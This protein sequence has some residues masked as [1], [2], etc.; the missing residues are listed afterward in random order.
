M[1]LQ[2]HI[3]GSSP[4]DTR[5]PGFDCACGNSEF[6][7]V[8]IEDS[9]TGNILSCSRCGNA[10]GDDNEHR[11]WNLRTHEGRPVKTVKVYIRG[12]HDEFKAQFL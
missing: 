5:Q 10:Y 6:V 9:P 1:A 7:S 8:S 3:G 4:D 2:F 11:P 12:V